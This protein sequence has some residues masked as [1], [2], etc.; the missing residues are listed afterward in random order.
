[1]PG[2]PEDFLADVLAM[3]NHHENGQAG[4]RGDF[5]LVQSKENRRERSEGEGR[6][7]AEG[8]AAQDSDGREKN[9]D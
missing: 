5:R 3:G 6:H 4:H 1:M 8:K 7:A 2:K 9:S